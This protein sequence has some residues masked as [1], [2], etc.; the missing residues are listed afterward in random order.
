M[1]H[2]VGYYT[3]YTPGD[4]GLLAEMQE[5]YGAQLQG[6]NRA[7]KLCLITL[8]SADLSCLASTEQLHS[9]DL[10]SLMLAIK[11]QL[12]ISDREGLLE[13]LISGVRYQNETR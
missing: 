11:G 2:P 13:C 12:A 5:T 8:I 1:T 7:D 9:G 3:G 10:F 6:L 4:S